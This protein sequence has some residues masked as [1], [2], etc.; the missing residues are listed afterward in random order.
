MKMDKNQ[1]R[2]AGFIGLTI[3]GLILLAAIFTPAQTLEQ[4]S[5]SEVITRAKAGEIEKIEV[6]GEEL[7]V[8][9]EPQA[10]EDEGKQLR[11]FKET[12]SNLSEILSEQVNSG[13]IVI[14]P[15]PVEDDSLWLTVL[16]SFGPI[17]LF[18]GILVYF[19]RQAQGQGNQ[20]MNFGKSRAK[21]FGSSK[22]D[23]DFDDVAGNAESKEELQE[24]VEF[25]K[26]PK[27]FREVGAKIPKGVLLVGSPGTGK[28]LMARAVAGEASV[29][30]FSISGSEFV[31]LRGVSTEVAK[32]NY[33]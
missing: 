23:I 7:T 16:L 21:V 6:Q 33:T 17:L 18:V 10:G 27:K 15:Q 5:F 13:E 8:T 22:E 25:L 1:K 26:Y 31:E 12:D 9:L 3:V 20:A 19:M 2:N 4:V 32:S 29:P 24:V 28:T 14:D 11:S 30:F